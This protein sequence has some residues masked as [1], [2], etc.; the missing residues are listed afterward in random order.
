[1]V[2]IWFLMGQW[3]SVSIFW[4]TKVWP[5]SDSFS[6][7]TS[8]MQFSRCLNYSVLKSALDSSIASSTLV[9]VVDLLYNWTR[10]W[11]TDTVETCSQMDL[12]SVSCSRTD[13][14]K[15]STQPSCVPSSTSIHCLMKFWSGTIKV[16]LELTAKRHFCELSPFSPS[17]VLSGLKISSW[18]SKLQ[19]VV[20]SKIAPSYQIQ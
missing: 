8:A 12:F 16:S 3:S 5:H 18:P 20:A 17:A 4:V 9:C 7:N 1:M 19:S 15:I 13:W 14:F 10:A 2:S 6:A 11:V